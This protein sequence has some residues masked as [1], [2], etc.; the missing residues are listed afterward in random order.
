MR[1]H[2]TS[3]CIPKIRETAPG[4][5][6]S[7]GI[8]WMLAGVGTAAIV[9]QGFMVW[10]AHDAADEAATLATPSMMTSSERQAR[11]TGRMQPNR[12]TAGWIT[13]V[14]GVALLTGGIWWLIADDDTSTQ[15]WIGP[16]A[17]AGHC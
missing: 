9:S 14:A 8:G 11:T 10:M 6:V 7:Q 3:K 16:T 17:T 12:E 5:D 1:H 2:G 4:D 15:A 13:G